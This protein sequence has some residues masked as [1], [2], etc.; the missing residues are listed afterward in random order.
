MAAVIFGH[1][2]MGV[3]EGSSDT[4]P[5]EISL[6]VSTSVTN[7]PLNSR[8]SYS[9]Q[10]LEQNNRHLILTLDPNKFTEKKQQCFHIG[11]LQVFI[12]HVTLLKHS[13]PVSTP[14]ID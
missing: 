6:Q 3:L 1:I 8:D 7:Q 9:F 13:S 4:N 14:R 10:K 11:D 2:S 12:P 5:R